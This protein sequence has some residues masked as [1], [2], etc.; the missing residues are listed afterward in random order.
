MSA[1][2]RREA[3][4]RIV[5]RSVLPSQDAVQA[6]LADAGI[7]ATQATISRDLK[8]IGAVKGPGGYTIP[9]DAST[10]PPTPPSSPALLAQHIISAQPALNLVV[11]KTTPGGAQVVALELDRHPPAGVV[12]TVAGDDTVMIAVNA[13]A[14]VNKVCKAIR[15]AAGLHPS[16]GSAA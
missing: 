10:Q 14:D 15:A 11:L 7:E 8:A 2:A 9:G 13:R 16:S 6:V 12:G 1:I 3:L 4:R 5:A